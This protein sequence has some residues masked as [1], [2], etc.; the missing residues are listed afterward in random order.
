VDFGE[1]AKSFVRRSFK[2]SKNVNVSL[3]SKV[4]HIE[5]KK[6]DAQNSSRFVLR[7][8]T[9]SVFESKLVIVSSGGHS[10]LMAHRMGYGREYTILSIAGSFFWAPKVLN[11]KVYTMQVDKL[12]FAAVHGDPDV[13]DATETRFGPTAKAIPM[14]ERYN[15]GSLSEYFETFGLRPSA[16]L[17]LLRILCDRIIFAYIAKNFLYDIP[18]LGRYLFLQEVRKIV[19]RLKLSELRFAGGMGGTRPQTVNTLTKKLEMGEAKIV[20]EGIIFNVTPSPGASTCLGNAIEDS[21]WV[22]NNL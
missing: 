13:H 7:T 5:K 8:A 3:S 22:K 9:G 1:L 6:T 4:T 17:S 14:L 16:I 12:P 21:K 11:G 2:L 20:G 10:L 18:L 19:P 15:W